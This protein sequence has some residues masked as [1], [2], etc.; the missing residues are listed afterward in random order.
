MEVLKMGR[1][2]LSPEVL[3]KQA[4]RK[5]I[6]KLMKGLEI[7]DMGDINCLFKEMISSILQNGLEGELDEE[8]GYSKYD[9]KNRET[10]NYR[11]GHNSKTIK[12]SFGDMQLAVPRD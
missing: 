10:E 5:Q 6:C 9:Y 1:N 3:E 4:R 7:K 2:R 11:T 8:L 12:T